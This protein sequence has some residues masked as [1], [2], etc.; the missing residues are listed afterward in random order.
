MWWLR[1]IISSYGAQEWIISLVGIQEHN[2]RIPEEG[3]KLLQM[4]IIITV[5]IWAQQQLS[6]SGKEK[7]IRLP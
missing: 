5:Y 7:D 6:R 2:L 1:N 3:W 4:K